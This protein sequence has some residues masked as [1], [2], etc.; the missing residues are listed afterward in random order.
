[1]GNICRSPMAE[2]MFRKAV[3]EAGLESRV[4]T[5]S[6]GTHAYHVGAPPDP[7]AQQ[8]IRQ[9]GEDISDLRGRCV[10]DAD[11][12]RFD[13]ILVM[14][15]DNYDRLIERAPAH[16]H[17]K[18]RRLLSFSRR[19]PNLDVMDPYYGGPQGFEENLDMIE[20]AVQGLIREI[21]GQPKLK[22]RSGG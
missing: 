21:T 12:E 17:G 16:H 13:Y 22:M 15:G 3:R 8:A 4:E 6:A 20:D 11:F 14:D 7:R 10:A 19:W 9:R 18:I 2:G 5:D 1:M